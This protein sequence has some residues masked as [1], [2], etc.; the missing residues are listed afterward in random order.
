MKKEKSRDSQL[1]KE[2]NKGEATMILQ[3]QEEEKTLA[4]LKEKIRKIN[5]VAQ[6]GNLKEAVDEIQTAC[7]H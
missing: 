7:D 2:E 3:K 4:D 5:E 1:K 6:A